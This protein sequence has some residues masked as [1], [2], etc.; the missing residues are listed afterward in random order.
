MKPQKETQR[1]KAIPEYK[2]QNVQAIS[3]KIS[4]NATFLVASTRGLP[5]SQFQKIKKSF[6]GIADVI[7]AK[8]T[9]VLRALE[10]AH[11][12]GIEGIEPFIGE[13]VALFVSDLDAFELAGQLLDSQVPTKA[14]TGDIAPEDIA[15]EPGPT[16][17]LPGPAISELG[18]VGL[19]VGVEGGKIAIKQGAV[20]VKKGE[21]ISDKVAAVMGKLNISPMKVGFI[22]IAAYD[23]KSG[24]I[25]KEM[26]IDKEGALKSLQE[27]LAKALGFAVHIEYPTQETTKYFIM[28][29]RRQEMALE[30][31]A[32]SSDT[33]EK[34]AA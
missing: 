18:S 30:K 27:S 31:F 20:I 1:A 29:A 21:P 8:R 24:V 12:K 25:F 32:Q 5:A 15:I 22:P 4:A 13:N 26:K 34:E 6:R 7:F 3:K 2:V 16:E 23:G 19:K 33:N 9:I 28:K 10:S 14:K 17:L 11:K